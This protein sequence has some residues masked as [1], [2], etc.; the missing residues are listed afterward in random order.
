MNLV[1]DPRQR[2]YIH[3]M[4]WNRKSSMVD[5]PVNLETL[6][7]RVSVLEA[8]LLRMTRRWAPGDQRDLNAALASLGRSVAREERKKAN[9]SE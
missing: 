7:A 1:V 6:D 9:A 4:F 8:E 3:A 2:N 5:V